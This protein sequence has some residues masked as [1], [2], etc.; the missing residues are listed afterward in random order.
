MRTHTGKQYSPPPASKK[1]KTAPKKLTTPEVIAMFRALNLRVTDD[2]NQIEAKGKELEPIYLQ[3]RSSPE[4]LEVSEANTWFKNLV[5][6]K[7]QRATLLDIVYTDFAHLANTSLEA[8][9]SVGK[10]RLTP[11]LYNSLERVALDQCNCDAPLARSFLE[12]YRKEK[13]I[14]L[15]DGI[16]FP[17][18][19]E[20]LA[21]HAKIGHVELKWKLP[22]NDC[23]E[24]VVKRFEITRAGTLKK[25]SI[26]LCRG[27][28][29]SYDDRN[30]TSG[31]QYRYEVYSI[32]R[33]EESK[34]AVKLEVTAIGEISNIR[35]HWVK[36]H[37]ELNWK[38][39]AANC[40]VHIFRAPSPMGPVRSGPPTPF[41][42]NPKAKLCKHETG[43]TWID[44]KVSTAA[45]YH[46]LLVAYFGPGY[47]SSGVNVSIHTP[48]PPP[49]VPA[50]CAEYNE[51]MVKLSWEKSRTRKNVE[52]IVLR[53]EGSAPPTKIEDG[54]TVCGTSQTHWIDRD[55]TAGLRYSY[56]VF[57]RVEDIYSVCGTAA[58]PI[59]I[60]ADV[61]GLTAK[62]GD[63]T[64]ELH[65]QTPE[66]VSRV[67]VRR[68]ESPPGDRNSGQPVHITGACHAK[69]QGLEN[70]KT[71]HYLVCC[72]YRPNGAK[73]LISTGIRIEAIPDRLPVK[74]EDF[75][76]H[77]GEK[78]V[79]C[80]WTAPSHGQVV[81]IRSRVPHRLTVG[82]RLHINTLDGLGK[83]VTTEKGCA[84]DHH[85][86]I[87][88]PHY[89]VFTVAGTN[90]VTG[91]TGCGVVYPDITDL[92]LSATREGII[93]H[94]AW[95]PGCNAVRIVRRQDNW[96]EGPDDPGAAIFSCTRVEYKNYGEKFVDT[97]QGLGKFHYI[98]YARAHAVD[99]QFYSTGTRPG[100]RAIIHREPWMTLRYRLSPVDE[101]GKKEAA[102][103]INWSIEAPIP[104]F[105]G[106]LL[107]ADRDG[108]PSSPEEGL[109]IFRWKPVNR[110]TE[111][112]YSAL[113]D[114]SPIQRSGWAHFYCKLIPSDPAQR[115]TTLIIHPN[116][117]VSVSDGG[118]IQ[119]DSVAMLNSAASH[120]GV[121]IPKTVICPYC[122][123]RFPLKEMLFDSNAGGEALPMRYH[124]LD[125]LM[126]RPPR[127]PK[128]KLGQI[129]SRKICPKCQKDLPFTAG[130]QESLI[131]GIIGAKDS[132]K[133]HYIAALIQRLSRQVGADFQAGLM[134][135]TDETAKRYRDE[136]YDPLFSMSQELPVTQG[137]PPPLI[138][139]LNLSGKLWGDKNNRTVTLALYDTA[140]EKFND[141]AIVRKVL[142]YLEVASGII[143]LVDPLQSQEVR[144]KLQDSLPL[145][146]VEQNAEPYAIISRV[147]TTL[148]NG[149]IL[150]AKGPLDTPVAMALTK[151]DVLQ[152]SELIETNRLWSS[153]KRH[154]GY[155]NREI[156]DDMAG[157]MGESMRRWCIDA[158]NTVCSRFSRYAF[159]GVSST[160]CAADQ[161]TGHYKYISPWR[162]EDP[163]LWLLAGLGI[164][165]VR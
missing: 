62:S 71:Y 75:A 113:I 44:R 81:V 29:N 87:N 130:M 56:S 7:N 28:Q 89:S 111:G 30:V 83:R 45:Q 33:G 21:A 61:T 162:V 10:N 24:I 17:R 42:D 107:V 125:R 25:K 97:I 136:F 108:P 148:E 156:H 119:D 31:L 76:V 88:F 70:G 110:N 18:L 74:V 128:N 155:F 36:D 11:E 67:I 146:P 23:D 112:S 120:T 158:Y 49:A 157:M 103:R 147:L 37:V 22:D 99:G 100:C 129:L 93:M 134:P 153:D 63:G 73:E 164:I 39:P 106:F 139:D 66:N 14:Q 138:Y 51:G 47:Y 160:G 16:V 126:H 40:E 123:A 6:L 132:G 127:P 150:T 145:P 116:T 58:P 65:W 131:I 59:D 154:V 105:A 77:S 152:D 41:T 2:Q 122:F 5:R 43:T 34:T 13:K 149:K 82:Q 140:G 32:W 35:V 94:W 54:Q 117:C 86:D 27:R 8:A 161:P 12:K 4:P 72:A 151:C 46:Y 118:E 1:A 64:I 15:K 121:S 78:E 144:R 80:T 142:K 26:Q 135:V 124:W 159:F 48:I 9:L 143:F 96:P 91:G 114:L 133:S 69:D 85:P 141:P 102:I 68:G 84:V 19:V 53:Q 98:V 52:Y 90:A 60:L 104:D 55:V 165:P 109:E 137:T 115:H 57:S 163:L 50:F 95:P 38:K 3:G 79:T 92:K 101:K 20:G